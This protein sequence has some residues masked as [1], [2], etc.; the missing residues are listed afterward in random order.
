MRAWG[1]RRWE[2]GQVQVRPCPG[3]EQKNTCTACFDRVA[4]ICSW[5]LSKWQG[6]YWTHCMLSLAGAHTL[7]SYHLWPTWQQSVM[8]SAVVAGNF[9]SVACIPYLLPRPD[10]SGFFK[11]LGTKGGYSLAL[12]WDSKDLEKE[13]LLQ[14]SPSWCRRDQ[15]LAGSTHC[16]FADV[17]GI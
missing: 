7:G 3:Q 17:A 2:G 10:F 13:E 15:G 11:F 16:G 5:V 9:G 14:M 8:S 4:G 6:T 1:S 12:C